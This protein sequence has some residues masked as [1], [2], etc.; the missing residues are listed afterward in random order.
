MV[1][2]EDLTIE[3]VR[4]HAFTKVTI[5]DCSFYVFLRKQLHVVLGRYKTERPYGLLLCRVIHEGTKVSNNFLVEKLLLSDNF[6][7]FFYSIDGNTWSPNLSKL[8]QLTPELPDVVS[9]RVFKFFHSLGKT[10][11]NIA[12]PLELQDRVGFTFNEF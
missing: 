12:S 1:N 9:I 8:I 10:W 2:V 11:P 5:F 7:A 3:S 4:A 6:V